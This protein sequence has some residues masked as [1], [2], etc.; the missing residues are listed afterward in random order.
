MVKQVELES[1]ETVVLLYL[2]TEL[3]DDV[4]IKEQIEEIKKEAETNLQKFK[5]VNSDIR[6]RS[7]NNIRRYV[8]VFAG[9]S[10]CQSFTH[11]ITH[12]Q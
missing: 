10:S 3:V 2:V 1:W 7:S 8:T 9:L 5:R 6:R 11:S 12:L 4:E